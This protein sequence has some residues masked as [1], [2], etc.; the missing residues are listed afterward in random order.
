MYLDT[1]IKLK[2]ALILPVFVQLEDQN[3]DWGICSRHCVEESQAVDKLMET[4]LDIMSDKVTYTLSLSVVHLYVKICIGTRGGFIDI[5]VMFR[6][7]CHLVPTN[8]SNVVEDYF[9]GQTKTNSYSLKKCT[10]ISGLIGS[11]G[12]MF[13]GVI[14]DVNFSSLVY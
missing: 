12:Q 4:K 2:C 9:F 1:V 7:I 8:V 11:I 10:V 6:Q 5:C 14:V 3:T 13:S